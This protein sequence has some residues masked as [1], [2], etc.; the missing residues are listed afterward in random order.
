MDG[1][2]SVPWEDGVYLC[3]ERISTELQSCVHTLYVGQ[4]SL[5]LA[6][7]P[8]NLPLASIYCSSGFMKE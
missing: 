8:W 7:V 4:I 1:G 6:A 5:A 3:S 2:V